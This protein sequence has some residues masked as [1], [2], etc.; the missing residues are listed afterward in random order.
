VPVAKPWFVFCPE[1]IPWIPGTTYAG[2]RK[3][4]AKFI[5]MNTKNPA[6][7]SVHRTDNVLRDPDGG[8]VRIG[9]R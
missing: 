8:A 4:P 5:A 7:A 1:E 6:K 2:L 3:R 9:M